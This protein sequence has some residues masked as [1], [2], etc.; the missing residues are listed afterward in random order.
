MKNPYTVLALF[1]AKKG[2]EQELKEVLI[3]L[4][5]PTKHEPGC[6][7]YLLHQDPCDPKK[8]MF[9]KNFLD[10]VV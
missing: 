3:S 4:I 7:D 1:E 10:I 5:E 9:D 6:I 8:F 2:K